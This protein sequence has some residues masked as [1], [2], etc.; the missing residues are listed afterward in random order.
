M[1]R[2]SLRRFEHLPPPGPWGFHLSATHRWLARDIERGT[3]GISFLCA[4]VFN[5]L[6]HAC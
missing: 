1:R 5:I 6:P 4:M 3:S 2:V